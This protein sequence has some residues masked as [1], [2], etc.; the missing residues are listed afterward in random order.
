MT[1][2]RASFAAML[3]AAALL[4]SACSAGTGPTEP[5]DSTQP[6]GSEAAPEIGE[7]TEPGTS[8]PDAAGTALT[9]LV[10]T[11]D[12]PDAYEISLLDESG[13]P[14]TSLPAGDYT[15]TFADLSTIHNFR[16]TGP[17]DVD[18]ATEIGGIDETTVEITL[19]EGTYTIVCDPHVPT[20]SIELAVTA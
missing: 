17:G 7:S 13:S 2:T 19:V 8:D 18:V 4:L 16:L 15:L 12:D 9:G 10:G 5:V 1:R 20:M 14:V 6:S 3:A 11:A